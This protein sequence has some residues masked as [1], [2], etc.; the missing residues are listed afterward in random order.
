MR[1]KVASTGLIYTME[2][3]NSPT[4]GMGQTP[5]GKR[6]FTLKKGT[7]TLVLLLK[8]GSLDL[9]RNAVSGLT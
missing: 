6:S 3:D 2:R 9:V 5:A 7:D 8:V 4:T 1:C